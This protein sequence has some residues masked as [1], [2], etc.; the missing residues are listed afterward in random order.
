MRSRKAGEASIDSRLREREPSGKR[1]RKPRAFCQSMRWAS[2]EGVLLCPERGRGDYDRC[3]GYQSR[4]ELRC[5]GLSRERERSRVKKTKSGEK[6]LGSSSFTLSAALRKRWSRL[7]RA[8]L[9]LGAAASA[10]ALL[11]NP[12]RLQRSP[13]ASATSSERS[14][15]SLR[16]T[17]WR[18]SER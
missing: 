6:N 5:V 15:M 7:L 13:S 10:S 12:R 4:I 3:V 2:S 16:R 11:G 8:T 14:R 18:R 1:D 17:A 9:A